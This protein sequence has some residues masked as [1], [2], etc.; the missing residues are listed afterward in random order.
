MALIT[1]GIVF[2]VGQVLVGIALLICA[3]VLI[4][5]ERAA[6]GATGE[7]PPV[8]TAPMAVEAPAATLPDT[9]Y[10]PYGYT[11]P[12]YR[13]AAEGGHLVRIKPERR[14]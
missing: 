6:R 11:D 7:Q 3:V 10:D 5:A 8:S 14:A 12:F 4:L 9:G 13:A 1:V 2:A